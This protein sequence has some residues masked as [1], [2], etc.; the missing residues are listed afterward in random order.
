MTGRFEYVEVWSFAAVQKLAREGWRVVSA[1]LAYSDA[2]TPRTLY[3]LER[4]VG[5]AS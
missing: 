3:V 2:Y 1:A 5:G 4:S